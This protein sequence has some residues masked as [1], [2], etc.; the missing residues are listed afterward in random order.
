MVETGVEYTFKFEAELP[1]YIPFLQ[2]YTFDANTTLNV[3]LNV[4][5]SCTAPPV[6]SPPNMMYSSILK[7]ANKVSL[8]VV[9]TAHGH[10]GVSSPAVP[11]MPSVVPTVSQPT[12]LVNITTAN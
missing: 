10:G 11:D 9:R 8:S 5:D 2:T 6:I 4:A 7:T 3:G 12:L 1:G